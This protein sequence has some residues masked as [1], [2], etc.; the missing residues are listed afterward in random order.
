MRA[1][2]W[3]TYRSSDDET[4]STCRKWRRPSALEG[5]DRLGARVRVRVGVGVGVG[6]GV[7]ARARARARARG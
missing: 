4:S 5:E 6:V 2:W 1:E 7:R 3:G